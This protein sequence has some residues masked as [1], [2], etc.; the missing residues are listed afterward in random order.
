MA[1]ERILVATDFEPK[2]DAALGYGVFL[3]KELRA[4]L[5]VLHVLHASDLTYEEG[6]HRPGRMGDIAADK[7]R[8]E[9]ESQVARI[10]LGDIA[11]QLE[12]RFGDPGLEVIST[13]DQLGC[14][15]IVSTVES[16]S[17]LGKL[18]MGSHAQQI[19]LGSHIPVVG[20]K[21]EWGTDEG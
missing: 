20:V 21:P 13:A 6:Q 17:R 15:L 12:V 2:S 11:H 16:R 19:L 7:A 5:V 14:E 9:M 18:L 8:H 4:E 10:G 1:I 3:A